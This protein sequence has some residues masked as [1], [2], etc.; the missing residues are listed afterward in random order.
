MYWTAAQN[1]FFVYAKHRSLKS[2]S[3]FGKGLNI[4]ADGKAHKTF[5]KID[6]WYDKDQPV[7]LNIKILGFEKSYKANLPKEILIPVDKK[8]LILNFKNSDIRGSITVDVSVC[9]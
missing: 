7:N 2:V 9:N 8:I 5:D 6:P 1:I 3:F 4:T